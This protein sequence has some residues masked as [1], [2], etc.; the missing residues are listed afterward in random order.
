MR[1]E[2][3]DCWT[4]YGSWTRGGH[5]AFTISGIQYPAPYV[6]QCLE[7]RRLEGDEEPDHICHNN[8]CCRPSHLVASTPSENQKSRRKYKNKTREEKRA[9][10]RENIKG[11][12]REHHGRCPQTQT[13]TD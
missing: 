8:L 4:Y 2:L 11:D 6:V 12:W 9:W 5:A 1:E 7:N 13:G 10:A 3:G